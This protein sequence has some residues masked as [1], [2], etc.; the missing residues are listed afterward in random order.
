MPYKRCFF[1]SP[2]VTM[3]PYSALR[4]EK[5]P[6]FLWPKNI[7]YTDVAESRHS[8][9]ACSTLDFCNIVNNIQNSL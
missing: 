3:E 2:S 6:S 7:S 1:H 4:T 8:K 9:Q 5:N